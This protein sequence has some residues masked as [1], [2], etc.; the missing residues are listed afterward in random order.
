MVLKENEEGYMGKFVGRKER[1]VVILLEV[2]K[3]ANNKR[4]PTYFV[5][6]GTKNSNL[7]ENQ[8]L[9]FFFFLCVCR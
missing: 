4:R 8:S 1:N 5:N 9:S 3:Q 6:E 7:G 2:Q